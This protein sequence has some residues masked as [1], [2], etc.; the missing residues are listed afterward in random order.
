MEVIAFI[1]I[2]LA[3]AATFTYDTIKKR[4][5]TLEK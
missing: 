4:Q 5:K 1:T 3:T 2:V